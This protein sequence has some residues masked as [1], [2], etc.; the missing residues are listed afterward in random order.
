MPLKT[1]T[2]MMVVVTLSVGAAFAA[3][4][5]GSVAGHVFAVG[6]PRGHEATPLA[7]VTVVLSRL[8]GRRRDPRHAIRAVSGSHGAFT[9]HA[10][11]GSYEVSAY[12]SSTRVCDS[13]HVAVRASGVTRVTLNCAI[14]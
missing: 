11:A 6:G 9:L 10:T 1:L 8:A 2:L 3:P 12:G 5:R 7:G 14:R 13:E 4:P